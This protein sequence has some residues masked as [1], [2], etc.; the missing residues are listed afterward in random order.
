M[1]EWYGTL[2][3]FKVKTGQIKSKK[4]QQNEN[5]WSSEYTEHTHV[6]DIHQKFSLARDWFTGASHDRI[7]PGTF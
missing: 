5:T 4:K 2:G 7:S 3:D 6:T 1:G